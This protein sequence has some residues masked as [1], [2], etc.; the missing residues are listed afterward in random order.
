[1]YYIRP[2][3]NIYL[4]SELIYIYIGML[5]RS[6]TIAMKYATFDPDYVELIK[7]KR[8]TIEELSS[9]IFLASWLLQTDPV[10]YEEVRIVLRRNDVDECMFYTSFFKTPNES[11]AERLEQHCID[12]STY[13]KDPNT[14]F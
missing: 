10:I 12:L 3:K 4:Y 11:L 8:L 14:K 2:S 9:K 7:K 5:F 6:A 1:M 13:H